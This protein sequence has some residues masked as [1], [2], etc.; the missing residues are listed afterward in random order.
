MG[1]P[2]IR[3][4]DSTPKGFHFSRGLQTLTVVFTLSL[5]RGSFC[6]IW[7]V[8][9]VLELLVRGF[10]VFEYTIRFSGEV[11]DE[12]RPSGNNHKRVD[13]PIG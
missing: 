1:L 3:P 12:P 10:S 7:Y 13:E 8:Q 5:G 4:L 2:I 6:Q 11:P 9:P